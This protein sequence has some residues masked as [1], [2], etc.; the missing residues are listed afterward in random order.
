ME[1]SVVRLTRRSCSLF[2]SVEPIP[3]HHFDFSSFEKDIV[4][5]GA[6]PAAPEV[7]DVD[8]DG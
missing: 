7:S 1:G 2:I 5:K 4:L 6:K 8:V 3:G